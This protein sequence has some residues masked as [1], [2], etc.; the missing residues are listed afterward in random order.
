MLQ[1]KSVGNETVQNRIG[2]L[3]IAFLL[4]IAF[5]LYL[6]QKKKQSG[7]MKI[8]HVMYHYYYIIQGRG[9]NSWYELS[10][11]RQKRNTCPLINHVKKHVCLN[12][13]DVRTGKLCSTLLT[14]NHIPVHAN[15]MEQSVVFQTNAL[16]SSP[17]VAA[18][19]PSGLSRALNTDPIKVTTMKILSKLNNS[20]KL[21]YKRI[22]A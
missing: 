8:R 15:S 9:I 10:T 5:Y 1:P 14:T 11:S 21:P 16:S 18:R 3:N 7:Y 17:P 2:I 20:T 13:L 6:T 22:F 19:T 12:F 4:F